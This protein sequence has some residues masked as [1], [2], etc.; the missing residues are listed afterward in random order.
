M[1]MINISRNGDNYIIKTINSTR[2]LGKDMFSK[3]KS[4]KQ[5]K[6]DEEWYELSSEK[7]VSAEKKIKLD[8]WLKDH[9]K[10]IEHK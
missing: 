9:Q 4:Y 6:N 2:V 3:N 10:F 7:A 8:R 1:K 5:N